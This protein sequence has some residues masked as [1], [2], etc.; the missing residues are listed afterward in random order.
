MSFKQYID[1]ARA[2]RLEET[3]INVDPSA[4]APGKLNVTVTN[5]ANGKL[6]KFRVDGTLTIDAFKDLLTQ[7]GW[8]LK[9]VAGIQGNMVLSKVAKEGVI[10]FDALNTVLSYK[11]IKEAVKDVTTAPKAAP[12]APKAA[13]A[14]AV[15]PGTQ[16]KPA[17]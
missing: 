6:E 9:S 1:K 5:Q 10:E 2:F 7:Q 17:F 3:P 8:G 14:P 13:P 12:V 16:P 4:A 15:A 11:P